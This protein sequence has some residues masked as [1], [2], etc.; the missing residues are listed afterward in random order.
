MRLREARENAGTR[1]PIADD[2]LPPV[3]KSDASARET[4]SY[5]RSHLANAIVPGEVQASPPDSCVAPC[6]AMSS[7]CC[8][9][10]GRAGE[11]ARPSQFLL[12][13]E[14]AGLLHQLS[15]SIAGILLNAQ[16]LEWK[17][18]PYSHLKRAVREIERNA[19]RAAEL[20]RRFAAHFG[21]KNASEVNEGS[22]IANF[23]SCPDIPSCSPMLPAE[24]AAA[25]GAHSGGRLERKVDL[26]GECDPCTSGNFPKRDDSTER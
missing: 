4:S 20:L 24:P 11:T 12:P 15:N 21:G 22:T 9:S 7:S 2:V 5:R 17:L 3:S 1:K 23:S 8:D 18:P 14:A 26:T 10:E 13:R 16:L 25:R 19:Q 6:D